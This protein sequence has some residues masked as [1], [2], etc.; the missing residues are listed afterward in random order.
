MFFFLYSVDELLSLII[1]NNTNCFKINYLLS[2]ID[3]TICFQW[4]NKNPYNRPQCLKDKER[5]NV[6][7]YILCGVFHFL[8]E[9]VGSSWPIDSQLLSS[10]HNPES[11]LNSNA[12]FIEGVLERNLVIPTYL[13]YICRVVSV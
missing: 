9:V 6:V 10:L 4:N 8:I 1:V 7:G 11:S 2:L 5:S 12:N 13:I 3:K